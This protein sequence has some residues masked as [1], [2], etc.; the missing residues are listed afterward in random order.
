MA[1]S[2]YERMINLVEEVFSTKNDPDQ[3]DVD[4][5]V[6]SHLQKI[7]PASVSEY[8]EGKGP[9]AWVL[10][11]PTTLE[12]MQK[13]LEK[14]ISEKELYKLTPLNAEYDALYLC[15]ATV[16]EEYRRKGIVKELILNAI[17]EIQKSHPIKA[18]FVWPFT[19]DGN[20]VAERIS[21]FIGLPLYKRKD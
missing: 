14:K 6:I 11:I 10:L 15:S 13:F 3:L 21:K 17:K 8:D 2:N 5:M 9:V 16:L 18:M 1:L 4:Q 20:I 19:K 12:L 7:H